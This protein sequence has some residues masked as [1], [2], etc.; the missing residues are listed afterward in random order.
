LSGLA[1]TIEKRKWDGSI[2]ARWPARLQRDGGRL[3]WRTPPGTER[4]R[5]RKGRTETTEHLEV[6]ATCGE[7]WIVTAFI[8]DEGEVMR[9]EVDATTGDEVDQ[10]GVVAFI[11]LDVD[12][13]IEDGAV[14]VND[15]VEFA[16]RREQMGYPP[17]M[18]SAI[19]VALDRAL[20]RHRRGD[21]PFD[22][23]LR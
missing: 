10:D 11:D 20:D 15:L 9:Y 6:S 22:G 14:E 12:M 19:V 17:G 1:V 18:L 4:T 23:S 8:G 21:W 7:G 3:T 5:P 2:S 16:E 13:E